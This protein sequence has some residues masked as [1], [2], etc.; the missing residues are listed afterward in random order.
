MLPIAETSSG[1]GLEATVA[2]RTG[3]G[4]LARFPAEC[5]FPAGFAQ[6]QSDEA[7]TPAARQATK[8]RTGYRFASRINRMLIS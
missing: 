1:I 2:N 4:G 5:P 8:N 3:T 6:A 7:T